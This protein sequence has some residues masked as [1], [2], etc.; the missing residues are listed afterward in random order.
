MVI[1]MKNI[2][3]YNSSFVRNVSYSSPGITGYGTA[4][5]FT[6]SL[7]QYVLINSTTNLNLSYKS[8]TFQFWIYPFSFS[9][10]GSGRGMIGLCQFKETN[11]CLHLTLYTNI[12]RMS[13][14]Y[15]HCDSSTSLI[16]NTWYH[17]TFVYN[18]LARTQ[19]IY[20]NGNLD[21]INNSSDPLQITNL[22]NMSLTVGYNSALSPYY[23]DGLI[24]QLSIVE[25]PKNSSEILNDATLVAYY[26]FN[27]NSLN[28]FG[29]NAINGVS[30]ETILENNALLLNNTQSYFQSY[31][32]VLL[33][34]D[35]SSYSFSIWIYPFQTNNITI[36]HGYQNNSTT[37][38]WCLSFLRFDSQGQLQANS[39]SNE[40]LITILGPPISTSVWTHIVQTYSQNS[41]MK[42]YING[43][44]FNQSS[45]ITYR[46]SSSPLIFTIRQFSD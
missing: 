11:K 42:L 24:D 16:T 39:R 10:S 7:Q 14:Y 40:G 4:L 23:Y 33:G 43:S 15:T 46:S 45:S 26:S 13:F 27:D 3:K 6:A 1:S 8:F 44:L 2:F 21:C 41:G 30:F 9:S 25:W 36:L 35:N 18:Y 28:D 20:I 37:D 5:N 22:T 34:I 12:V 38:G 31:G 32:F 17:L 19:S 29:P